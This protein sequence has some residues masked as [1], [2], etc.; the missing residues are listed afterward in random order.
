MRREFR[1]GGLHCIAFAQ[2]ARAVDVVPFK[3]GARIS[4]TCF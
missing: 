1:Q 4:G 2:K 3:T